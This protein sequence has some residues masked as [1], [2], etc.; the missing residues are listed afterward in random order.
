MSARG[1]GILIV[2]GREIRLLFTNR[3]LMVAERQM[4]KGIIGV[5]DGFIN[6]SSGFNELVALMR[7]GMDAARQE[8]HPS[9]KPISNKD[10]LKIVDELG[11]ADSLG[12]VMEAVAEVLSYSSAKNGD[13]NEDISDDEID[14]N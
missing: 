3:A 9:G 5:M 11:F 6:G 14:P 4:G 13:G 1:E 10:A 8:N 7:A 12:P 2:D